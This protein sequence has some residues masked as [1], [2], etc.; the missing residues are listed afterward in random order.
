MRSQLQARLDELKTEF[1]TGQVRLQELERQQLLL[2]ETLLRISGAIQI[3][4]ELLGA[5]PNTLEQEVLP[6]APAATQTGHQN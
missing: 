6:Y 2:R 3:L 4:E 5:N 1:A